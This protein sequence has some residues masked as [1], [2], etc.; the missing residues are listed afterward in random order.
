MPSIL[1][2][3]PEARADRFADQIRGRFGPQIRIVV[4]PLLTP[5]MLSP[6]LPEEPFTTVIFTSETAVEAFRH[7]S[8]EPGLAAW[9]VGDQTAA[10]AREAGFRAQSGGAD[11]QALIDAIHRARPEGNLVYARGRETTGDLANRLNSLG[12][13]VIERVVYAQRAVPLNQ[14]AALLLAG[15]APVVAPVFSARTADLLGRD[16]ALSRRVA[17]LWIAA[18]SP[19]VAMA[20]AGIQAD[21]TVCAGRPDA[22]ALLDAMA[23]L[24]ATSAQP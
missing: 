11:V 17:P 12:F 16:P 24:L 15:G 20:C 18:L 2:T 21:R 6:S 23:A 13:N 14:E 1:L 3:R 19:A 8:A 5:Q 4:S 7:L 22:E 9:C 10:S